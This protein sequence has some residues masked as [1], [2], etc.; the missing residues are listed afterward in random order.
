MIFIS[1]LHPI[2]GMW[3]RCGVIRE[4]VKFLNI[5]ARDSNGIPSVTLNRW[6]LIAL[7]EESEQN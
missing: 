1:Y 5:A 6:S 2:E 3:C 7:K 4:M